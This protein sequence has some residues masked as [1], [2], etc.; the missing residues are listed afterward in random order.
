MTSVLDSPPLP[1]DNELVGRLCTEL[2]NAY[3]CEQ[4]AEEIVSNTSSILS[5]KINFSHFKAISSLWQG[6]MTAASQAGL[7]RVLLE[8]VLN[9]QG[10]GGYHQKIKAIIAEL[11]AQV[12]S[13]AAAQSAASEHPPLPRLA[14][15]NEPVG[16]TSGS[17]DEITACDPTI[18]TRCQKALEGIVPAALKRPDTAKQAIDGAESALRPIEDILSA[19]SVAALAQTT[20]PA[21]HALLR[22]A[23]E[24]LRSNR[25]AVVGTL[26]GLRGDRAKN[27]VI[28]GLCS[29][30]EYQA[31]A[32]RSEIESACS[33]L[34]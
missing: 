7:L 8:K 6:I 18:A 29:T 14:L 2:R 34:D 27:A 13:A 21:P 23:A 20:K 22:Q 25:D 12:S 11:D 15:L 9:D 31:A 3:P 33:L 19:L 24:N 17:P 16:D 4:E 26:Q 1:W 30:L 28:L 5:T 10:V 32:L